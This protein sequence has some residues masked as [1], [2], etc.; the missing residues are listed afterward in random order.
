MEQDVS[1]QPKPRITLEQYFELERH[2]EI[3]HEYLEGEIYAMSGA[4]LRH[5]VISNNII[6]DLGTQLL[7]RPC[8]VLGPDM[9]ILVVETGLYTYPDIVVTCSEPKFEATKP[10]SLLN[11]QVI[12]EVLS[13][14]TES[15]DR[16]RK[17]AHYRTIDSL[18]EYA[19]VSQSECRIEHYVRRDDKS[20]VYSDVKDPAASVEL[21]SIA[22]RLLLACVYRKIEFEPA[23]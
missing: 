2:S 18:Q 15:Y 21:P 23:E 10:E 17:F 20:W 4:T 1:T 16:G 3:R 7:D 8:H 5:S 13:D 12:F 14:S 6:R 22:C 9:R 11:P 19:L